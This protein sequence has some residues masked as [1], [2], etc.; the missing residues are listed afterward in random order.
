[1]KTKPGLCVIYEDGYGGEA[2]MPFSSQGAAVR[3]GFAKDKAM[4]CK[5]TAATVQSAVGIVLGD[6]LAIERLVS[7]EIKLEVKSDRAEITEVLFELEKAV[8]WQ[9]ATGSTPTEVTLNA[10]RFAVQAAPHTT[11]ARTLVRTHRRTQ[12]IAFAE[13]QRHH[14]LTWQAEKIV[15][16]E[17]LAVLQALLQLSDELRDLETQKQALEAH[18]KKLRQEQERYA[19][20]LSN[21]KDSGPEA[22]VRL[23]YV[24]AIEKMEESLGINEGSLATLD[25]THTDK[26]AALQALIRARRAGA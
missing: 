7:H 11:S 13:L 20:L 14:V 10:E 24:L 9:H 21:L 8:G 25:K 6:E 23:R 5:L 17:Q 4:A 12:T 3:L 19:G 15:D 16:P 22:Q 18:S 2:M 1:L 26:T